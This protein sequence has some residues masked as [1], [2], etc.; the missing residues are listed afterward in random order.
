MES[1]PEEQLLI[2]KLEQTHNNAVQSYTQELMK[3]TQQIAD[4]R[5][6]LK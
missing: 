6:T 4:I 1:T 3:I 5:A 2:D